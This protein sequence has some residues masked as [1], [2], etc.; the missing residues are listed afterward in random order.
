MPHV[1]VGTPGRVQHFMKA[2]VVKFDSLRRLILDECDD[3]I[4]DNETRRQIQDI[5]KKTPVEKQVMMCSAT[6]SEKARTICRQISR[7]AEE[8]FID[9]S[10]LTLHGLQQYYVECTEQEK[11]KQLTQ[12]LDKIDFNQIMIFVKSK[13]RASALGSVLEKAFFPSIFIHGGLKQEERL[14]RYQKFKE[15][16]SRILVTTDLFGRG[17]DMERVN[18][19]VNF[20]M[21]KTSND[22]LHRVGRAGRFGTKG[23][24]ITLVAD[25]TDKTTLEEI[26]S[27]FEMKLTA[28]PEEIE[29]STYMN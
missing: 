19:V 26:D 5:F 21:P 4:Q 3:M 9:D 24:A 10:K 22:Y 18:I 29:S 1:L 11:I 6:L 25:E 2:G 14:N 28:L 8:I 12:L 17:V 27:R 15:Y 13:D 23:L 16:E 20:D 7:D